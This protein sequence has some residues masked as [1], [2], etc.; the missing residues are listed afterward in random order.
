MVLSAAAGAVEI[1]SSRYPFC[2]QG[3]AKDPN[4]TSG[5]VEFF[6]FN[7]DL[8]RLTLIVKNAPAGPVE[9]TWGK[10][11]KKFDAAELAKGINLA[12]EFGVGNPFSEQFARVEQIIRNQQNYETTLH[13]QLLHE[14]PHNKNLLPEAR[15]AWDQ[16][17]AAAMKRDAVLLGESAAAVVPVKHVIKIQPINIAARDP[18]R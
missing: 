1:E 13:K 9:I 3:E 5:I 10:L 4:A 12:A 6:P 11:S 2:F 17:A 16:V 18:S 7:Q 14:M 15:D 8:N